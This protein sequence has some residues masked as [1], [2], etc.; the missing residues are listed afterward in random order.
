MPVMKEIPL[1]NWEELGTIIGVGTGVCCI[2]VMGGMGGGGRVVAKTRGGSAIV[3]VNVKYYS[4]VRL[5]IS[6]S[7]I[8]FSEMLKK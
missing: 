3:E 4:I 1:A 2:C 7:A 5:S 6:S 8:M